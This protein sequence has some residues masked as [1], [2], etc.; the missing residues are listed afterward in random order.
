MD[1]P[2]KA[3][4]R[5]LTSESAGSLIAAVITIIIGLLL[6]LLIL[7]IIAPTIA[8]PAFRMLLTGGFGKIGVLSGIGRVLYYAV[9]L[10]M[11]GLAV[12]FTLKTG[13]FNIG[14]A[15]QYVMGLFAG[16]YVG[17]SCAGIFG[18]FTWLAAIIAGAAA[19]GAWGF[20]QG[21]LQA[22][23]NL[24]AIIC[25]I[26][27]NYTGLFLVSMIVENSKGVYV[28]GRGWTEI[29]PD[30]A[31]IP[32]AGLNNLFGNST[33]ANLS[34][35]ICIA[36]CIFAWFILK[37]TTLGYRMKAVGLNAGAARY[38]GIS[39]RKSILVG[40]L[41]AGAFAGLGGAMNHL[42]ASGT[43]YAITDALPSQ[44]FAGIS[45]ALI[46]SSNPLGI[47]ISGI[48]I[49]FLEV[50]G[51]GMQSFGLDPDLVDVITS[52]IIYFCAFSFVFKYLYFKLAARLRRSE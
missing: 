41:L 50:G 9:P 5:F 44:G 12:G 43:R 29:V 31:V 23:F 8:L 28:R 11:C 46:A 35:F 49:A 3:S 10:I 1:K 36:L 2:E 15:G 40:M 17:I 39:V 16:L 52:V 27:M 33:A 4:V 13:V 37:K 51:V 22:F 34:I 47:I 6:G 20:I 19:G 38:A 18:S 30:A 7:L 21:V 14:V 48:F 25:G 24:N 42:G 26:M 32:R 45:V